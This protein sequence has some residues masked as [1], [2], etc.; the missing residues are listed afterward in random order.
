MPP[1]NKKRKAEPGTDDNDAEQ[2]GTHPYVYENLLVGWIMGAYCEGVKEEGDGAPAPVPP[3]LR[4]LARRVDRVL[5]G[6]PPTMM[7]SSTAPAPM[8]TS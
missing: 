1:H 7:M 3:P 5:T 6:T 8:P 2:H 4:A